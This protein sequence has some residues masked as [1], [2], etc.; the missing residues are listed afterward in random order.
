MGT[1]VNKPGG[2]TCSCPEGFVTG[3]DGQ[4]VDEDECDDP[5]MCEYECKNTVGSYR[6]QCPPGFLPHVYWNHCIGACDIHASRTGGELVLLQT[7]LCHHP[8]V[9]LSIY[10]SVCLIV[11]ISSIRPFIRPYIF[12]FV[13]PSVVCLSVCPSIHLSVHPSKCLFACQ[14]FCPSVRLI[15]RS[16]VR[17]SVRSSVRLSVR[18]SVRLSVRS[19]VRL[20]AHFQ[21]LSYL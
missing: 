10:S 19:S 8:Y 20:S 18:S 17:L 4:C 11:G 3:D 9:H 12:P 7:S 14:L 15:V 5:E 2:F 6:C 16:S 1:C 13:C 21:N